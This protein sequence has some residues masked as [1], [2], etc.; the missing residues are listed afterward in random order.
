MLPLPLLLLLLLLLLLVVFVV[1]F[2][3]FVVVSLWWCSG[4]RHRQSMPSS[5]DCGFGMVAF[6]GVVVVVVVVVVVSGGGVLVTITCCCRLWSA[7]AVSI[8]DGARERRHAT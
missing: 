6:V 3:V 1:V 4:C 5:T 7:V 8:V 2:V